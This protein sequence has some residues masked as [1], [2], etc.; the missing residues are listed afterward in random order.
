MIAFALVPAAST[1]TFPAIIPSVVDA[2]FRGEPQPLDL[3]A[4]PHPRVTVTREPV[5][6]RTVTITESSL[7]PAWFPRRQRRDESTAN[8]V[9]SSTGCGLTYLP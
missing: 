8:H 4:Y 9:P 3:L 1:S 7:W 5:Q 2:R 6:D